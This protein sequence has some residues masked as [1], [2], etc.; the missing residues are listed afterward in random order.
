MALTKEGQVA[1]D[2]IGQLAKE[3]NIDITGG[4]IRRTSSRFC[5]GVEHG[6]YN[7]T[8]FFDVDMIG[9]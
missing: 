1:L 5:L 8:E 7:G 9:I 6:D 2:K 4:K 3:N